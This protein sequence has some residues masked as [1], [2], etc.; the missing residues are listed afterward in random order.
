[1]HRNETKW[2]K[3]GSD[4]TVSPPPLLTQVDVLSLCG[5]TKPEEGASGKQFSF[6]DCFLVKLD[7][8]RTDR[9]QNKMKISKGSQS[10]SPAPCH[11]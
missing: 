5:W 10:S 8:S 3:A 11:P 4:V 6:R 1:M 9:R 7:K 2:S